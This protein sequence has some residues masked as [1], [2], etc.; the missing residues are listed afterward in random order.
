MSSWYQEK[1]V[2]KSISISNVGQCSAQIFINWSGVC[3]FV[4]TVE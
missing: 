2:D 3:S 4:V 1:L